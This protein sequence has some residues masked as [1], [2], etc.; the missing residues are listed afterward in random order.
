MRT[1]GT[2]VACTACTALL[3]LG[4]GSSALAACGVG[5]KIWGDN[6][7]TGG[8]IVA[9]TTNFFTWKA[10]STTFE[11]AGCTPS[12]NWLRKG[13]Q[14]ATSSAR[15][16]HFVNENLDHLAVDMARGHGEHLDVLA[17]LIGLSEGDEAGFRSLTQKNFDALF[18]HDDT[19]AGEMLNALGHLMSED[20][21]LAIYV[22]G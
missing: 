12:D 14:K 22:E 18:P 13:A 9:F 20:D 7:G 5:N 21:V 1:L 3:T 15:I 11:I 17:H 2:L 4:A 10:I 6:P 16:R 19:N 8:K